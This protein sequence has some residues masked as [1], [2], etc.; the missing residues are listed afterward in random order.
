MAEIQSLR[1]KINS[2]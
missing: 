2:A 1:G